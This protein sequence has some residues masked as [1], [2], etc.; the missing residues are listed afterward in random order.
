MSAGKYVS[1]VFLAFACVFGGCSSNPKTPQRIA[2]NVTDNILTA[3]DK[4]IEYWS[5]YVAKE[6]KR[7]NS[8]PVPEQV[9]P[10]RVLREKEQKVREALFKYQKASESAVLAGAAASG[11]Q[12]GQVPVT[13][14]VT[15][16]ATIFI[17]LVNQFAN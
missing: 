1:L 6:R 12:S 2:F 10:F 4:A 14:S 3:A 13:E 11:A 8:L 15:Q 16:A 17:N 5:D 9:E 7:I